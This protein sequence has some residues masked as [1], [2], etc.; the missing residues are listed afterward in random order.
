MER[1]TKAATESGVL[2]LIIAAILVAV[3]AL[4]A[5]GGYKRIDTTKA[6]K[7][8]LS[9]GSANLVKSLKKDKIKVDA[10]VTKGLPKLDAFVRDLRDLLLEY[11]ANSD[12]KFEFR[13]IEAKEE[14]DKETAKE[15]GLVAQS[16]ADTNQDEDKL[17]ATK[18]YMGL[19]FNYGTERDAIKFL[20]PGQTDGLE[21]WITNKIREVRDK[22]EGIK[23]KI[24]VLQ[25]HDEIKLTDAN[26]APPNAGRYAIQPIITQNFTF[27][28]FQDVDLKG[29]EAEID[30]T[31]DGLIITQPG[32]DITE[33]ELRR[34]DQFVMKGKSLAVFASA[35]NVKASDATMNAELN[36]HGLDKLLEG[37]GIKVKKD[38][39]LDFGRS[40]R[41]GVMTQTGMPA[42]AL[43]P[44][45]VNVEDDS[46]YEGD[47]KRL[48]TAFPSFFRVPQVIWPFASSVELDRTKQPEVAADK[49]KII[50]RSTQY[51]IHETGDKVDLKP[52]RAWKPK[53]TWEQ[54]GL[55]ATVEGPLKSAF[56]TGDKQGVEAPEKSKAPARVLVISSSQYLANP[57]ARA[58]AGQE[59]GGQMMGMPPQG[60]DEQLQ[61]LA[62]PYAQLVLTT[63]ILSFKNTLDWITGDTDLLAVSAKILA[64]PTLSYGQVEKPG[65]ADDEEA[66]KKRDDEAKQIRHRTQIW[67]EIVLILGLPLLFVLY[68]LIRWQMRMSSRQKVSL[69]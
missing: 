9:R 43:F 56:L 15:A 49:M 59:M 28:Q 3:N 38:V 7:Y 13:I 45:F 42:T 30:D 50:A 41:V 47:E 39:V 16:F 21:F 19:V 5:I 6:E 25:G 4:S 62:M 60:G 33:K 29:G 32:K 69:A 51:A 34:I 11:Q 1:R 48:D 12:G 57:L 8:T 18:G 23:H 10:Y 52:F 61:Q 24:G 40:F 44:Q 20:P 63:T 31:L 17:E 53:G 36:N 55:A 14:K 66:A 46:R 35:V 68:G 58:G 27:Y 2:L 64:E 37:Y 26:L 67:I 22:A 65:M 54:F